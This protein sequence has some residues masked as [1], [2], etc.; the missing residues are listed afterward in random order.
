MM[1]EKAAK[2]EEVPLAELIDVESALKK[3]SAILQSSEAYEKKKTETLNKVHD[4]WF[5]SKVL[6][7]LILVVVTMAALVACAFFCIPCLMGIFVFSACTCPFIPVMNLP[8]WGTIIIL[9]V[10][11]WSLTTGKLSLVWSG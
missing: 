11:G 9:L 4:E 8:L 6:K 1:E 2:M 10:E 5:W 7:P 3:T